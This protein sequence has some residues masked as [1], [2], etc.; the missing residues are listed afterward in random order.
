MDATPEVAKQQGA[1]PNSSD[2]WQRK[3]VKFATIIAGNSKR[4]ETS[5]SG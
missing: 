4:S 1:K 5:K 2:D 3:R